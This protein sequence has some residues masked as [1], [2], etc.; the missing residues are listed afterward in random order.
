MCEEQIQV[1]RWNRKGDPTQAGLA[2][3]M[4]SEGLSH[5]RWSNAPGDVYNVHVHDFHKVI[6]VVRG[7]IVFRMPDQQQEI[8]LHAGDR[9]ELPAGVRHDAVVGPQGVVCLEAHRPAG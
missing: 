6:L 3:T 7:S 4:E 1:T 2:Q 9:L 5:F 8:E